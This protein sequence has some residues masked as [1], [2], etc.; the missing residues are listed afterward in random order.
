MKRSKHSRERSEHEL[1]EL[2]KYL[3]LK[4]GIDPHDGPR[5]FCALMY[6]RQMGY[7]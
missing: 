6:E 1:I 3:A 7:L 2:Y 4:W 5:L